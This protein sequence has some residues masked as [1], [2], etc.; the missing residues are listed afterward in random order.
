MQEIRGPD[1]KLE[2]IVLERNTAS[3]DD[4]VCWR[5]HDVDEEGLDWAEDDS[6]ETDFTENNLNLESRHSIVPLSVIT[7]APPSYRYSK[8]VNTIFPETHRKSVTVDIGGSGGD[9]NNAN[10]PASKRMTVKREEL[11]KLILDVQ[12]PTPPGAVQK[13]P[14]TF[15]IQLNQILPDEEEVVQSDGA[16]YYEGS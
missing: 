6:S 13:Q 15:S 10:D 5:D 4:L 2:R 1:G 7:K 14:R 16:N 3:L 9:T 8:D 12:L 11:E